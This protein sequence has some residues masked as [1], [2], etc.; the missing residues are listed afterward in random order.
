M[1]IQVLVEIKSKGINQTF[2]YNVPENLVNKIKI[3][4]RVLVPFG[5]QELEGFVLK[6]ETNIKYDYE[7]KD[8]IKLID[9]NPVLNKEMLELGK[10]I[11]KKTLSNLITCYQTM[12]PSALKAKKNLTIN[13]KYIT[14]LELLDKNYLP[15]TCRQKNILSL[16]SDKK[17][18]LK[19]EAQLISE[20]ST[21]TLI[22]NNVLKEIK[23]EEYRINNVDIKEKSLIKLNNEQ[24][25]CITN[26]LNKKNTFQPFLI[27]GVTGS[28]KT[29]VY[30]NL[31]ENIINDNKEA[32]VL[33]PE[34]SLT[35]Q[36]VNIF[37][38]RFGKTIAILHSGLSNGEKYDEWRK[39]E[40]KEV[41]VVIGARSAIFGP[42]TNLGIIIIDEEHET[43]YKQENNPKYNAIDIALWRGK[44]YNCPV[45]LGS[46]TP[47]IES[48]TRA[49]L[50]IYE[51]CELKNRI[52]NKL[53][54]VTLINMKDEIKK[55]KRILS[56]TL[57]K[58]IIETLNRNEQIIL[59]LNRRGYSTVVTCKDCGYVHKCNACDIPL[60]YHKSSNTMRCHYCGYGDRLLKKCPNCGSEN[61]N[62]FGIGTE[63]L[64]QYI[65]DNF[66]KA[67]VIRMDND[68]TSKKGSHEK[69]INSFKNEEYN[70]LIGTQM[71]AKGLDFP[72]VTLVGVINGDASLNI[73][74][75]RSAERTFDL[76]NQVAG[77][78]GRNKLE[79]NVIIQGFNIEHYSI[80]YAS[81][82]N[83]N[84]FYEE[85]MKLRKLLKYSPYY[86]ISTI[87]ITSK[88]YEE[89]SNEAQKI[90]NHLNNKKLNNVYILGPSPGMIPK[91]NNIYN[92]YITI[93]YKD[94][95]EIIKELDFIRKIYLK[96]KINVDINIDPIRI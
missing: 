27:H 87:K 93:K 26:I 31:I 67:K 6:I 59:L 83:Y 88:K 18:I 61:I 64:E 8:I 71:I 41:K 69:I 20:S 23:E 19:K 65:K 74:D 46:A 13:K 4:C 2:S 25:K 14:Y 28:G 50:N 73:P 84:D 32:I 52:N 40:K 29:E 45:V 86:N 91:I 5:K 37:K 53:P 35:P 12:L 47:S 77:R 68:T 55:G 79:G 10:Y 72:K 92:L 60:T 38:K 44:K 7:L 85:E 51:L 22:K 90:I 49:K 58:Q 16:F 82:H 42:F 21:K 81:T 3:G 1:S 80:K 39:I 62:S 63:K 70:V 56:D 17:R 11:S 54:K 76:L 66:K 43:T 96:N 34:I 95:K 24:K 78:A 48:Y 89:I 33:V 75:Y 15:K 9:I 36:L 94:S 57:E 30:M